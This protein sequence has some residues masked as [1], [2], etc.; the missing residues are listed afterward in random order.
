MKMSKDEAEFR[1]RFPHANV[2]DT[3]REYCRFAV[4]AGAY[5]CA[6]GSTKATAFRTALHYADQGLITPDPDEPEEFEDKQSA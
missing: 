5:I 4:Y 6:E 2:R 1:R 3:G